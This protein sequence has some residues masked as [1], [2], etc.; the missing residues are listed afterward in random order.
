VGK[1]A[2]AGVTG[3][4][5][6][7]SGVGVLATFGCLACFCLRFGDGAGGAV[8]WLMTTVATMSYLSGMSWSATF[9][10]LELHATT[11]GSIPKP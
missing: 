7:G 8:V 10:S 6:V 1:T 2:G 3:P 9:A 5:G 4:G 11:A